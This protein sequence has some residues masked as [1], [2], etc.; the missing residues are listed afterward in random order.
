MLALLD[1]GGRGRHVVHIDVGDPVG[2][3]EGAVAFEV[4]R[5]R[6][7]GGIQ[8]RGRLVT[9]VALALL[10]PELE[11]DLLGRVVRVFAA[12]E[13]EAEDPTHALGVLLEE[14]DDD[15]ATPRLGRA[16]TRCRRI[17]EVESQSVDVSLQF[18]SPNRVIRVT[19][20]PRVG[21]ARSA[22]K[23]DG[24]VKTGRIACDPTIRRGMAQQSDTITK[25]DRPIC[26]CTVKSEAM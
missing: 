19:Y 3:V 12:A 23:Y 11:E 24:I 17:A 21:K 22:N 6:G 9:Q 14:I 13:T 20:M 8:I 18:D 2:H 1:A 5:H 15:A 10:A 26:R 25:G 4:G 7:R 16:I